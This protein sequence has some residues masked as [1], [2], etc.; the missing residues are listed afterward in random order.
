MFKRL[1]LRYLRE[2][3]RPLNGCIADMIVADTRPET[4]AVV[5]CMESTKRTQLTLS[6]AL[7]R[8]MTAMATSS[9]CRGR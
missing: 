9:R 2:V 3:A 5:A 6:R 7:D 4:R 1:A 8:A